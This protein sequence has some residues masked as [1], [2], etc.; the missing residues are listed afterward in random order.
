MTTVTGDF[1]P[2]NAADQTLTGTHS[3]DLI[4]GGEGADT[5][6][7]LGEDDLLDGGAGNDQLGWPQLGYTLGLGVDIVQGAPGQTP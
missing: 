3:Q 5:L 2:A 1:I 6:N 4:F 7:G